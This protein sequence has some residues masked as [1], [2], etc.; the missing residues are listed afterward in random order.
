MRTDRQLLALA[1]VAPNIWS[2]LREDPPSAIADERGRKLLE[3]LVTQGEH[4]IVREVA[5]YW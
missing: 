4:G 3:A 2:D 1:G 5:L